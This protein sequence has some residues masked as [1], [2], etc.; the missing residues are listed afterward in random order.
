MK[1]IILLTGITLSLLLLSCQKETI[2][3]NT[4]LLVNKAWVL[5]DGTRKYIY[6]FDEYGNHTSV[7]MN[8]RA[9]SQE[10]FTY[11]DSTWEL[12]VSTY[13]WNW[14]DEKIS[15][16]NLYYE[17]PFYN[18]DG[19]YVN[20]YRDIDIIDI[21]KD[22]LIIRLEAKNRTLILNNELYDEIDEHIVSLDRKSID[23]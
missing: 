12:Y 22:K 2:T 3:N 11:N 15:S 19:E 8:Y 18:N 1:K 5:D 23:K 20:I 10:L 14:S 17:Y 13:D 7:Y 4:S 6:Y 16:I 21:S 9:N